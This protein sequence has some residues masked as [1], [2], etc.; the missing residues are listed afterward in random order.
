MNIYP[1]IDIYKGQ[2]VRLLKGAFDQMTVYGNPKEI[3]EKWQEAG[4]DYCHIV[5]LNGA[6]NEGDNRALIIEMIKSSKVKIQV[7][8]GIRS[9]EKARDYLEAGA[10][11]I[12]MGTSVIKNPPLLME[13]L[14]AYPDKIAVALD[15]R[16]EEV[17]LEGWLEQS[18]LMVS[19]VLNNLKK[20]PLKT[21]IYTD[22]LKDGTMT[23]PNF[24]AYETLIKDTSFE[25]VASGGV[26]SLEDIKKLKGLGAQGVILGKT[27]YEK[28]ISLEEALKC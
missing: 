27:L 21:I 8:G 9:L 11:K 22:I 7:G 2:A 16:N 20:T 19:E 13:V 24:S 26:T 1:A 10:D 14:Q 25:I 15:V 23:G 18:G 12:I 5:D 17:S 3:L 4:A 28:K 6:K